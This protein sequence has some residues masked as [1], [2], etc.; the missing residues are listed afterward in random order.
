M[1]HAY[2]VNIISI[3][4]IPSNQDWNELK[5]SRESIKFDPEKKRHII[6][7]ELLG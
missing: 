2:H 1:D 7:R 3:K 4:Y 6:I 5:N